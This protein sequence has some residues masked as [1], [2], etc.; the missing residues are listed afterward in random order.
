MDKVNQHL[1]AVIDLV[2]TYVAELQTNEFTQLVAFTVVYSRLVL[3]KD[4]TSK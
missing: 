3:Y 4:M 2:N 1:G